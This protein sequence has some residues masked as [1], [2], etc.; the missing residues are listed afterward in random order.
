[1]NLLM[2]ASFVLAQIIVPESMPHN[3]VQDMVI[4]TACASVNDSVLPGGSYIASAGSE[5][6]GPGIPVGMKRIYPY[7]ELRCAHGT[8]RAYWKLV[9]HP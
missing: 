7:V 8:Y 5:E 1:M 3:V 2:L 9:P 6:S 4:A